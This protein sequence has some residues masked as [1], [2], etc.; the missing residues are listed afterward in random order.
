MKKIVEKFKNL[1]TGWKLLVVILIAA[2]GWYGY[3][4]LFGA[5]KIKTSYQTDT[6]TKGTLIV[7]VTTSGNISSGNSVNITTTSTGT[8]SKV[9]VKNGDT[10]KQ[11]QKIAEL[12]LDQASQQRQANAYASYLNALSSNQSSLQGQM[13]NQSSLEA[14]RKAV[15]D[16]KN[17]YNNMINNMSSPG[18]NPATKQPYTELE[19][20]SIE[21][22][23]TQANNNFA[24]A[25]NK[26]N[27]SGTSIAASRSQV[28]SAYLNYQQT[29]STIVAPIDG[30]VS[31]FILNPGISVSGTTSSSSSGNVSTQIVGSVIKAQGSIQALANLTEIDVTKVIPGQKVSLTLDAFPTKTFTGKVLSVNTNGQ[32]SSGVT[33]YPTTIVLDTDLNNIYPNM[34]VNASIIT[35]IKD[36]VILVPSSAVLTLNGQTVVRELQNGQLVNVNAEVGESNDT[37][38]EI[39]SG[40]NEGDVVVTSVSTATTGAS[41]TSGSI[42]GGANRGFGG[43]SGATVRIRN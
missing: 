3:G 22:A 10:V 8:V 32:V 23:L 5:K 31:N 43:A 20:L 36:N 16:A 38:T 13:S 26:Y 6:A 7:T 40:V 19:R 29:S 27:N 11:G 33:T 4:K 18:V 41:S 9:Y 2:L 1:P 12:L 28:T 24:I 30:V 35:N 17:A 42:F 15:L 34:S 21:S 37:Q 14:A 25:E 39:L